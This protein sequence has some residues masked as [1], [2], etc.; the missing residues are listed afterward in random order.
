VTDT[1]ASDLI[2]EEPSANTRP[3]WRRWQAVIMIVGLAA[4]AIAAVSTVDDARDQALPAAGPLAIGLVLQVV[5]LMFVERGWATLF[6]PHVDGRVLASG[7]YASQ[8]TKYLPA[9]GLVQAASQVALSGPATGVG[10]AALRL[11]VFSLCIV[12]AGTTLGA[13][14]VFVD[15][16]PLWGRVVAGLGLLVPILL[17]RRALALVLRTARRF[18]GRLPEPGALPPQRA[19]LRCFAF[20]LGNMATYAISFAVLI[21]DIADVDPLTAAAAMCAA[22]VVGYVVVPLPSG[23]GVREAI[24]IAALPG[25]PTASLLAASLAQRLL[26]IVAEAGL[27]GASRLWLALGRR[28]AA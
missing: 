8:L 3:A 2:P 23:L 9:G 11:P 20:G 21:G 19:I 6:P 4:I 16:L 5:A 26:G 10:S 27:A 13:G 28:Q 14:L 18:V 12:A 24:L 22:W 25:I 15:S 7:F 1:D 17:D